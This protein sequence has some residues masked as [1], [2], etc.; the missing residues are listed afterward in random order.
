LKAFS[1]S[2]KSSPHDVKS[3]ILTSAPIYLCPSYYGPFENQL[4]PLPFQQSRLDISLPDL[5]R[6]RYFL[7]HR[8]E[9]GGWKAG[10]N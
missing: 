1:V 3:E 4:A 8:K 9:F 5:C 10:G 2:C 7:Y 6:L